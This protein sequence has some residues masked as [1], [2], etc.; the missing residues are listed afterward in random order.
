M[1]LS[2]RDDLVL[3]DGLRRTFA[4][5]RNEQTVGAVE[6]GGAASRSSRGPILYGELCDRYL[7][8]HQVSARTLATLRERLA[9]SRRAFE[10]VRVRELRP[11]EVGRWNAGL[12]LHPTTRGHALRAMR[13]VCET[14]VRWGTSRGTRR[15]RAQ[16][17]CR[18]LLRQT[19]GRSRRGKR[20]TR[21]P[22]P[23]GGSGRSWSS[24]ARQ[25]SARRSG[26]HS[27]GKTSTWRADTAASGAPSVTDSSS[28]L[29]RRTGHFEG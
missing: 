25:G 2:S 13:Q 3:L 16:S 14:A 23:Q 21:S 28:R 6:P 27:S 22:T 26:R 11:E 4:Q 5:R 12:P 17:R 29:R 19:S 9:H 15:G 1:G 8:Q 18:P 24:R 7:G 10:D 20:S